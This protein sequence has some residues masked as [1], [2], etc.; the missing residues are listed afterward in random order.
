MIPVDAPRN[1][2]TKYVTIHT[3]NIYVA[4]II[5]FYYFDRTVIIS[6]AALMPL[7]GVTWIIG[8]F[9]VNEHT[10]VFAWIFAVLNSLQACIIIC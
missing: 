4:T 1:E 3:A 8:L 10:E 7:L 2:L 5:I 6:A 9:A